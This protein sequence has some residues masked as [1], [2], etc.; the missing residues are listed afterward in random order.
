[1]K[2]IPFRSLVFFFMLTRIATAEAML[3][4]FNTSWKEIERKMPELA[5][6]GYQS[7]WLPP[8]TKGSGG[9]SV[10]YDLWDRFDLG[11]KD[12]RGSKRTRYGTEEELLSLMK[13]AHRFGIRVYFDNIM[14]HNAFDIPGFNE[15]TP[16]DTYPGFVPEDFHLRQTEE[17][18]FRKW[19]NTRNWGDAWQVQYL[20][21]SDL[22]DIAQ[23]PGIWNNNFGRNEGDTIRKISFLRHPQNPGYYCYRPTSGGQR[24][25]AGQGQYVGF[26]PGNGL[27]PQFLAA[28]AEYYSEYVEEM[29]HRAVRWKMDRTK[30]DGLR[31]DA[32]KH[33][34][35]DFFG[36]T[37]AGAD[38]SSY[39][40][41]GQA[42]EQ[43]NLSRGFSDWSNHR[44]TLFDTEKARD[45]AMLF[46]EHLGQ[47]PGYGGYIDR[48]QRLV[49][50]DLRSNFN[51]LLGNPSSGLQ[52][53]D[54]EGS[55]GF[56]AAIAVTH[57][58]S[59]DSDFA[60]RR[61]LQHAFY[62]TRAGLPLVYTDGNYHAE[63]LS[64]SGGAFPRHSNT[65]FLGQYADGRLPNLMKI[66]QN[67][68]RGYQKGAWSSADLV[69]YE[70][71]DK[72]SN[73]GMTDGDGATALVMVNDNFANGVGQDFSTSFPPNAYLWQ[74][75][76]G[77]AANGDSM[78]GFFIRL[79]DAGGGRGLVSSN[80]GLQN[81]VIVPSG[82]YYVFSWKNPD[83][84][85][86]WTQGGGKAI[87]I[88]EGG[89]PA[90]TVTVTRKDGPDG[91]PGFNP[92]GLP[93]ADGADFSYSID[94][95]RVRNGTDLKFAV[96]ADGSAENVLIKLNGGIDLNGVGGDPAKRDNPPAISDDVFMG[97][98]QANFSKRIHAEKFAAK[99]SARCKIGSPGAETYGKAIGTPGFAIAQSGAVNNF[100]TE[101][102]DVASFL[103]HDPEAVVGGTPAGGWPGGNAPLQYSE[104]GAQISLWANPNPV[105]LGFRMFVY[106]TSDGTNP[107]GSGGEGVGTTKVT[108]MSYSHNAGANDW[109][110][111]ASVPKPDNGATFKYKIGISKEGAPSWFPS[112]S[113]SHAKLSGMT[114]VFEIDGF[115]ATQ[116]QFFPHNDYA[117]K[118]DPNT[119]YNSW[120]WD[121]QT[122]LDEGFHMVSARAF[123]NRLGKAPI[124]NTYR[125]TFYYDAQRPAGEI[126]FPSENDNLNQQTYG[127]VVRT[128]RSVTEVWY[129]IVDTD[130]ANDDSQ[131][132][133]IN[134]NGPGFEPF[135]DANRNGVRD[136]GE[137]Y[138]D[139]NGNGIWDANLA[140]SWARATSVQ[141]N[142]TSE[143]YP[144]EWRFDYRNIPAAGN[145]QIKVRLK[146]VSSSTSQ[147]LSDVEGHYTTLIRNVNTAGPVTRLFVAFPQSDGELVAEGYVMKAY[148]S[149]SLGDGVSD[150]QL[151]NEF[152]IT[153]AST[154]SGSADGG[155][156]QD[157][158]LYSIVRNETD[159]Y[160]AL[161]FPLP[162]LYNGRPDFEH[163][164]TV[165]HTRA[166]QVLQAARTVK[167]AISQRPYIAI[168][169]PAAIGSDGRPYEV[170]LPAVPNPT[171][172]QR[173][174][175]IKVETDERVVDVKVVV[176]MGG[177]TITLTQQE[178]S[179][180]KKIWVFDWAGID[181][182]EY[183]IRADAY[184]EID[185]AVSASARRNVTVV[186]R[187][188][189]EED[190][191]D[192]DDDDDGL[193]D[194][195]EL[196]RK[197]LPESN[198]ETWNNGD[199]HVWRIFGMTNPVSPDTDDD[200]LPDG[201]ESGLGG[202]YS[203]G[204]NT[205]TDTDGDGFRNF[206]AD[207]DPPIFNT[208]DNSSHPRFNLNRSRTDQLGGSM[209]DPSK[210]DTD[211]DG[212]DDG[213]EDL[214]RN[215]R[216]DIA[217]V[218]AG[219]NATSYLASPTTVYNTSR[220]DRSAVPLNG[221]FMETDPNSADTDL[222]GLSDSKEDANA[223]GLIDL[224]LLAENGDRTPFDLSETANAAYLIGANLPGAKSRAVNR[225]KLLLDYPN[226]GWPRVIWSETDPLNADTDGDGLPDGFE[227]TSGLDPLDNGTY[228][229]RTGGAGNPE[230]GA[231][232]DPD[233]DGFTNIQELQNGTK[234]LL[235]DSAG[236]PVANSIVIGT[237]E[238][239][240]RGNAVNDNAFTDW[241]LEDL[242]SFDE[243][244]GA[245]NNSQSGDIYRAYDGFDSSRDIVAFYA[246]DGGADGNFYF[247]LDM[248]DLRPQ[249]EEGNLDIYVVIDTGNPNSGES[250]LP[251]Q[252]D[253]LT[254]MKWEAV[255][256]CYQTNV[257]RVY[258]DRNPGVNST[259]INEALTGANGVEVRDQNTPDGFGK[260]YY[261][262]DLDA[263]EFSISRKALLDSG[264]NGSTKL[265]FQ[266]FT[267]R[268]G[269]N[270]SG[271]NGAG[272][273][274]IGGRNDLRDSI[275]D[276]FL[277]DDEFAAQQNIAANGRL[278]NW[279][280][281]DGNGLYP[282]QRKSA[283]MIL[284][285]HGNQPVLPGAETQRLIN[286]GQASGYHRLIDAHEAFAKPL[287]LHL[288][289]T[290]ATAIE[291]ASV[292]PA[293]NRPWRD[294]PA[295][296]GRIGGQIQAGNIGLLGT[297]FSDHM[298]A[299][300][301]N[302]Y[303]L[304]NKLLADDVLNRIYGDL[305]SNRV[306]WNPERVA[307]GSVFQ[308]IS[309]M[310]YT[311]TFID[312]M[313]HLFRWQGRNT[314]L[315]DDGYRLNRYHGVECFVINDQ[316]GSYR[317]QNLDNGFPGP[318]RNLFLR[319]ARSGTQDQVLV[320]QNFWDEFGNFDNAAAYDRNLRWAA[321]HP[322]IRIVTPEQI[323]DQEI[324]INRDGVGDQWTAIDRGSPSL[325]KVSQ[326]YIDHATQENYDNW[327]L[328]QPGREEGLIDKRFSIRTGVPLPAGMAYGM[329]TLG[330][331]K[332]ADL[333]W[334]AVAA[335][336]GDSGT[337]SAMFLARATAHT[338]TLLTAFHNQ[339]NNDLTKY[340]TGVYTSP[341]TDYNTLSPL[342]TRSQPQIRFAAIYSSV[343][344][345]AAAPP[346]AAVAESVD[347]DLDGEPEY[348]LKNPRTFAVFE[349][350]GGRMTAAWV[351]T[352]GTGDVY[353]VVGNFLSYNDR[354]TEE[355]GTSNDDG[356]GNTGARRTS[357]FKDW[358]AA[359]PN[360]N[361]VNSLYTA[362]ASGANGWTFTTA[363]GK[364]AKT[365]TLSD[366]TGKLTASYQLGGG[367]TK[368]FVRFGLSPHLEDLL[369]NGQANLVSPAPSGGRKEIRNTSLSHSV[370]AAIVTSGVGLSGASVNPQAIDASPSAGIPFLPD[371]IRMR[372]QP[373]TEQVELE[374]TGTFSFALEL[375]S[376]LTDAD[377]DMLPDDWETTYN[378]SSSDDG[379][380]DI[381]NGPNGDPDKDGVSNYREWLF[382]MNPRL[383][384]AEQLPTLKLT[385][386]TSGSVE[387]EFPT[388]PNRL[389]RIWQSATLEP[390][391][392][393]EITPALNT[394]G[395]PADPAYKRIDPAPSANQTRRFYRL[396]IAPS[397]N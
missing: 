275:T 157:R 238:Q 288:T 292:D 343:Q 77:A 188:I 357:A 194:L 39:G 30:A 25:S 125:Q 154:E 391:S 328:G 190:P 36:A 303:N 371:T 332:L 221:V 265:N 324:D 56:P 113:G 298:I 81:G 127:A 308:R 43:F 116:V 378:L 35:D 264:W 117:R 230:M 195:D 55:G 254:Q 208:T 327:Y 183:R 286:N 290:L 260:S 249:A 11:S 365:V 316:A 259:T 342:S 72:R 212:L 21:L 42:Q 224:E 181:A 320:I 135:T 7:L 179:G 364:I 284:L 152:L 270:N 379:S 24:H 197:N 40:Y 107:E 175:A 296:N 202:T 50:N 105:G 102:G 14:N 65:A 367:I 205:D 147:S 393:T 126:V 13:A 258:V 151:I 103:Y 396:E 185:G 38:S 128:D 376:T 48:G 144:L 386:I 26:G 166:S 2:P 73:G 295:F 146:E 394:F 261:N 207:V 266:V 169:E 237:G 336:N 114:T 61:E 325:P 98:E 140:E 16:I 256:A 33:V 360:S 319:K 60:A 19:D 27:T 245:G 331:G 215:G 353:Q 196:T 348:V 300:F 388:I 54:Q 139:L 211:D 71:I 75:A 311:Y 271:P 132:R 246:R 22:I 6:A 158:S 274:D 87:S 97:Y 51:N 131:T 174:T 268:D 305:P 17:G 85:R 92:L 219:G 297:T 235:D 141:P 273:G 242:I 244:H 255:V 82:G 191:N 232:G 361:Y 314:A 340:S 356:L 289:P 70:R 323:V 375:D 94:V 370:G 156:P 210:A 363:D 209:T 382:G 63:T 123:L 362:T 287:T 52:G 225:A 377:M 91:D 322:W 59:H 74:Y 383:S 304:D 76:R 204:T 281:A 306:F 389:Y 163:L 4:Y 285:T 115:D 12:Q 120:A 111:S 344:A 231:I 329:Q 252:V 299:Y 101:G 335:L 9:L 349:A 283:K 138:E 129:Q 312:Q 339:R 302:A 301:S 240:V 134:G 294:G 34:R 351:R 337:Q 31:L 44:D 122:G 104:D 66:H 136:S 108:E 248:Y 173:S 279:I 251:D 186:V 310:G 387:I 307:D 1:M 189:V 317:Y 20:G 291:W 239:V 180:S 28:N 171:P 3:Q 164:I 118:Q 160:H 193:A 155:V 262:A 162:N 269:T 241:T 216:V 84:A 45:D 229:M 148:F 184:L 8:P 200:L 278:F 153:L 330:D 29:L 217:L 80:I 250:A 203:P 257:G 390:Q 222:D 64:Q 293:A 384:D 124:Y 130:M 177:G 119:S 78:N 143:A 318:W 150:E 397:T 218:D 380:T 62:F 32:V 53:Y 354:E 137:P 315:S 263:V 83:P 187:Q 373:Q 277:N 214:N 58:Q 5:E 350:L 341:D 192:L 395:L 226:T 178:A 358:F 18:F 309:A 392:W 67:F 359:G 170:V 347:V 88:Y 326:D 333:S 49:D 206:V 201:L 227:E 385:R 223:N 213:R 79:G 198:S 99:D 68:A 37:G 167:A 106:H 366:A 355:E 334:N 90:E 381:D 372:N 95:P 182:G 121:M 280:G 69:A 267:T 374:G 145:A 47:P 57:A 161:S 346:A 234:P 133:A 86:D 243:Y 112:D 228:N 172:A 352:P 23:E 253:I 168:T 159:D 233:G 41:T 272:A 10:G 199:V 345:W 313:R 321:N 96:R 15:S 100:G 369:V 368:L 176:E 165:T 46:G 247:R 142:N 338:S 220:V 282:D 236:T 110:M 93:D 276:D 109:W 149:K 89:L